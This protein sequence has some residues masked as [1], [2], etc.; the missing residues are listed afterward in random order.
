MWNTGI[1][2]IQLQLVILERDKSQIIIKHP[3]ENKYENRASMKDIRRL[4]GSG[5]DEQIGGEK[6][7]E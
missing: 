6:E 3:M 4:I 7:A 5:A 2:Q 1:D